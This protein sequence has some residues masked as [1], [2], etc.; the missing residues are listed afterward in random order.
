VY[1]LRGAVVTTVLLV[2]IFSGLSTVAFFA[3]AASSHGAPGRSPSSPAVAAPPLD[4]TAGSTA[5][6]CGTGATVSESSATPRVGPH[7][8][9]GTTGPGPLFNSQ[10]APFAQYTGPYSYVAGGAALRNSGFGFINLTWP[11]GTLVAAYL[12]WSIINNTVPAS[13][14]TLNG[15]P[16]NG[17]W[18]AY[19]TPSPCW[20]PTY[21]Y[22]FAADV[23]DLVVNG[24]NELTG[25]PSGITT[26]ADPWSTPQTTP[27]DDSSSL[28][29]IYAPSSSPG[30]HQIT[31]ST[32]A[33]P[34]PAGG[35]GLAQLNYTTAVSK[36]ARTTFLVADGQL[37]DNTASFNGSVIDPNAFYGNDPHEGSAKWSYGNLSDTK[38]YSVNVTAG[39]NTTTAAVT[40]DGSDCLTWVGQVLSVKVA[41]QKGPYNV[42]F[43]EQ[44]L[45]DG[46]HWSVTTD[47]TTHSNT[48]ANDAGSVVF[49][50][51]NGTH[52]FTVGSVPGYITTHTGSVVV[53][54]GPVLIRLIFHELLYPI[55][56][57]QTGLPADSPWWVDL[58]NTSQSLN[59]NLTEYSPTNFTFL[60]GNGSYTF[61]TGEEGLWRAVPSSG[62][63]VVDGNAAVVNIHFVPP[64][65]YLV[66]FREKG[67]PSGTSWGGSTSANWGDFY[68]TTNDPTFAL[69][70]PNTTSGLDLLYPHEVTGYD[71]ESPVY[72]GVDGAAE[73]V[74]VPYGQL[75][76]VTLFETG[77]P[78]ATDWSAYLVNDTSSASS[79]GYSNTADVNF[80]VPN[81]SYTFT[82][83]PVYAYKATP[84]TGTQPVD[85]ANVT[86]DIRFVLAPTFAVRFN[87]TGL[88][89]GTRWSVLLQPPND[90]D[91][92]TNSSATNFTL[93]LPNGSY[94]YAPSAHGYEATPSSSY[95]YVSGT[96]QNV[97]VTFVK[98][99]PVTFSEYGLPSGT[100]WYVYF[101][102]EY[103]YS[104]GSTIF[105]YE[106]NGSYTFYA[107]SIDGFAPNV[108]SGPVDIAGAGA[109]VAITFANS[110]EPTYTVTFSE[111]G[112]P[113]SDSNWS[114]NLDDYSEWASG[115]S[116]QFTEP[117]G[118]F[119]FTAQSNGSYPATPPT[120][121]I[122]VTGSSVDQTIDFRAPATSFSV[123]FVESGLPSG[124]RWY[125]NITGQSGLAASVDGTS[126]TTLVTDLP[127]DAYTYTAVTSAPRWST[128]SPGHFTVTGAAVQ[129]DLPFTAPS[130][131]YLVTFTESGLTPGAVWYI[132]TSGESGLST[133]V[134][135]AGGTQLTISL[136]SGNY[137]YTAAT[138]WRN[139]TTNGGKFTVSGA[140]QSVSVTFTPVASSPPPE[141]STTANS[142]APFPFLWAGIGIGVLVLALLFLFLLGRRRKKRDEVLPAP[143]N[144]SSVGGSPPSGPT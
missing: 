135:S 60:E 80:S 69:L 126:G 83:E 41:A 6:A 13:N 127:N 63:V 129:V 61:T 101:G 10:V 14:A 2:V 39:S 53:N 22:T 65:L 77:L 19:A 47:S 89:P 49:K 114:V 86:V 3:P 56:V 51:D 136:P 54:G 17:T 66:T 81:G 74:T 96:P 107:Y 35:Q 142:P 124:S 120:G 108:T 72:F 105:V 100:Y 44:G 144:S 133:T 5:G 20:S 90:V 121:E 106:P 26:G 137:T 116:I 93:Y 23:T 110:E 55:Y 99:Y 1:R 70:L 15:A 24:T 18:T 58:V 16:V 115:S 111:S 103:Q 11:S 75:Y 32:G 143:S 64:P 27:M 119:P 38:T 25:V 131:T 29:I 82:V 68:N 85:G 84:V 117:N 67:L 36:S 118:S 132:N 9:G 59:S 30:P 104:Y 42:T 123:T 46:T 91:T 128:S 40:S 79:Y 71:V 43:E 8:D 98:E 12:V 21:I 141:K 138:G 109:S 4:V 7:P 94:Y 87:E 102:Y 122:N 95:F 125:V 112:L 78:L 134:T 31:V 140:P 33:L 130:S 52:S 76:T 37:P 97:S 34:I 113:S 45:N 73:T 50:L 92:T 88:A 62:P 48:V 139:F 28:V 57:N